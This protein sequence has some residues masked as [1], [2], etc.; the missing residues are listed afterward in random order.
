M[1]SVIDVVG[2]GA[3]GAAVLG[4][5]KA[6]MAVDRAG[7]ASAAAAVDAVCGDDAGVAEVVEDGSGD[8]ADA[9]AVG[10]GAAALVG[11]AP[12]GLVVGEAFCPSPSAKARNMMIRAA[13]TSATKIAGTSR[14][15]SRRG[16]PKPPTDPSTALR[17]DGRVT[18]CA[19]SVVAPVVVVICGA[20]GVGGGGGTMAPKDFAVAA[21]WRRNSMTDGRRE[22]CGSRARVSRTGHDFGHPTR[23][24]RGRREDL[25]GQERLH[26]LVGPLLEQRGTGECCGQ[27]RRKA[28]D[29][30]PWAIGLVAQNL[31]G[32]VLRCER[33]L[34]R[35][36]ER[37]TDEQ[38][39][40]PEVTQLDTTVVGQQDIARFDVP[41]ENAD[42]VRG[43]QCVR[44]GDSYRRDLRSVHGTIGGDDVRERTTVQ[45][46]R[47][48]IWLAGGRAAGGVHRDDMGMRGEASDR[49]CLA[50]ELAPRSG[51]LD[52]PA[53][54]L[55]GNLAIER[56]LS[57]QI[58]HGRTPP[59][60]GAQDG[61]AG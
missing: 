54:H 22:G 17:S 27:R 4:A 59:T 53:Q 43:R 19:D 47:H 7:K 6:V 55:D 37:L 20:D 18:V 44:D 56:L 57:G 33:D 51:V 38:P 14:T 41:M 32:D 24:G 3:V 49:V 39:G 9:D 40:D 25:A 52:V 35:R 46:L 16:G 1:G 12:I 11:A 45:E 42:V 15:L 23:E 36:G 5:G 60:K 2:A 13:T 30:A 29:V 21:S 28:V 48:Q 50:A 31:W 10:A 61:V 58:H 26:P 8:T 34:V